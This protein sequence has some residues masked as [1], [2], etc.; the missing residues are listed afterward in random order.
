MPSMANITVLDSDGTTSRVFTALNP[1]GA[2]GTPAVWRWEDATKLP[3]FRVRFETSSRWNATRT[4][5]K[6]QYSFDF[7]IVQATAVAGV[8]EVVGRIQCRGGD[9]IYPQNATDAQVA[10]A[11]ALMAN[12]LKSTLVQSVFTTGFA[13][14]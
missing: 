10:S 3:G 5:R 11:A 2:E 1:A 12:L 9:W 8:N 7:P 4:A 14:N 13:P 6:V